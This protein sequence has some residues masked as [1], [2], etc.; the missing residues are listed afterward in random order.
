MHALGILLHRHRTLKRLTL[1]ELAVRARC[2]NGYISRIEHGN[3]APTG[4]ALLG[5][6]SAA[7]QLTGDEARQLEEAAIRSQ[8]QFSLAR[9]PSPKVYELAQLF[10]SNAFL[11]NSRQLDQMLSILSQPVS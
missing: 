2:S 7:L 3:C 11:L 8:R 5:R 10:A 9:H 1:R 4:Q 6:L